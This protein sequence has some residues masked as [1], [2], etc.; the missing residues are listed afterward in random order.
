MIDCQASRRRTRWQKKKKTA[1][2]RKRERIRTMGITR[3]NVSNQLGTL[4]KTRMFHARRNFSINSVLIPSPFLLAVSAFVL[5]Y[6]QSI[7]ERSKC[8]VSQK[9]DDTTTSERNRMRERA[10]QIA[11]FFSWSRARARICTYIRPCLADCHSQGKGETT[12]MILPYWSNQFCR[13][14]HSNSLQPRHRLSLS[15]GATYWESM[16]LIYDQLDACPSAAAPP[17]PSS[18]SSSSSIRSSVL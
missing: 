13:Q 2:K 16:H 1:K 3:E 10:R 7:R 14:D 9:Q 18:S 4:A 5:Q 12:S 6:M 8:K 17:S 15:L 11:V